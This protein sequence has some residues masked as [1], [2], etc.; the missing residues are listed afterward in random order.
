MWFSGGLLLNEV[1]NLHYAA[2]SRTTTTHS[3]P[4]SAGIFADGCGVQD[5]DKRNAALGGLVESLTSFS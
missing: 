3:E 2:P 5:S 4:A 1:I